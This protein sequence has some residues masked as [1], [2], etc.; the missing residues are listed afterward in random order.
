MLTIEESGAKDEGCTANAALNPDDEVKEELKIESIEADDVK[1]GIGSD[2]NVQDD[3]QSLTVTHLHSGM[4]EMQIDTH[5]A[6]SING[7][8]ITS[9]A[10]RSFVLQFP[11]T[12]PGLIELKQSYLELCHSF[13]H[14]IS[15][16]DQYQDLSLFVLTAKDILNVSQMDLDLANLRHFFPDM[17]LSQNIGI[18]LHGILQKALVV[19][20]LPV[21]H[22]WSVSRGVT[23]IRKTHDLGRSFRSLGTRCRQ[24]IKHCGF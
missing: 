6:G 1:N 13:A 2:G 24:D 10:Y 4:S 14:K 21:A 22:E 18:F 15:I 19:L 7:N 3:R 9:E 5:H 16:L 17:F 11:S 12:L 20:D 23:I 8:K